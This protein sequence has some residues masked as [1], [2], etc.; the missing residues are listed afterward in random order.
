MR[1]MKITVST[2]PIIPLKDMHREDNASQIGSSSPASFTR[3]AFSRKDPVR[4]IGTM[5]VMIG[6]QPNKHWSTLRR[7]IP[8]STE[9]G[10][11]GAPQRIA[12]F[13]AVKPPAD[14]IFSTALIVGPFTPTA[15]LTATLLDI[16]TPNIV[17]CSQN[18][19]FFRTYDT[20]MVKIVPWMNPASDSLS[21]CPQIT[22]PPNKYTGGPGITGIR[23]IT[24]PITNTAATKSPMLRDLICSRIQARRML[25]AFPVPMKSTKIPTDTQTAQ[26]KVCVLGQAATASSC[27]STNMVNPD[28]LGFFAL[29]TP[30]HRRTLWFSHDKTSRKGTNGP[31]MRRAVALVHGETMAA[32]NCSNSLDWLAS[33]S[34]SRT[35]HRR[36]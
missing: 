6:V 30:R 35:I 15:C 12:H 36:D 5:N 31:N 18:V 32:R 25:A 26:T 7:K 2:T 8:Q 10:Q 19:T 23:N 14:R 21:G 34:I 28:H 16:C 13:P 4:Q 11:S 17:C 3:P 24:T 33:A 9:T 22:N 1:N 27:S 20:T 29:G